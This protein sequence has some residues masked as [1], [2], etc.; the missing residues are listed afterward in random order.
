MNVIV[1]LTCAITAC[2]IE[3]EVG[4]STQPIEDHNGF[5]MNGFNMNGFNMNGFNM[6]GFNMNGFNMNGFNWG[7]ANI[8]GAA[9]SD[10]HNSHPDEGIPYADVDWNSLDD[11]NRVNWNGYLP[12]D[13]ATWSPA[14]FDGVD[15]DSIDWRNVTWHLPNS[16]PRND[17]TASYTFYIEFTHNAQRHGVWTWHPALMSYLVEDADAS[18]RYFWGSG[19][20]K[21]AGMPGQPFLTVDWDA[22]GAQARVVL[23][24]RGLG[25]GLTST[26]TPWNASHSE[27]VTANL[28]SRLNLAPLLVSVRT[29]DVPT[30]EQTDAE[31]NCFYNEDTKAYGDLLGPGNHYGV[32][33]IVEP[34][35]QAVGA[36]WFSAST[37]RLFGKEI[38]LDDGEGELIEPGSPIMVVRNNLP[39]GVAYCSDAVAT[40][41]HQGASLGCELRPD[42]PLGNN[43]AVAYEDRSSTVYTNMVNEKGDTMDCSTEP[44]TV[45]GSGKFGK[46]GGPF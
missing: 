13:V 38:V 28:L 39:D 32:F 22:D 2:G 34:S 7:E 15:Y 30:L 20:A 3:E 25:P 37:L 11:F 23:G 6:N 40:G 17:E 42:S 5:N 31:N 18:A 36:G 46:I 29:D 45:G 35:F 19:V 21:V 12:A 41:V 24:E 14:Q 1:V 10:L 44:S 33:M 9:W 8:S 4:S 43:T 27:L 26:T 16:L